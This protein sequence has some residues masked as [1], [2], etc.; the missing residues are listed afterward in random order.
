MCIA[1]TAAAADVRM[2]VLSILLNTPPTMIL[3]PL[4]LLLLFTDFWVYLSVV[5]IFLSYTATL[6]RCLSVVPRAAPYSLL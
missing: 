6:R 5:G 1:T 2:Y 3:L 4:L